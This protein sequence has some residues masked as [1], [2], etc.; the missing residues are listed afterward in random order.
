MGKR[1]GLLFTPLGEDQFLLPALC[2]LFGEDQGRW[3][4]LAN[5]TKSKTGSVFVAQSVP[6]S[7]SVKRGQSYSAQ[8]V[9]GGL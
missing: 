7:S 8:R 2:G 1:E 9:A 5:A 3:M 4:F 6:R